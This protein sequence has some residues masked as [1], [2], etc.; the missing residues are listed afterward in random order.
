MGKT[1]RRRSLRK[2]I[3]ALL[4]DAETVGRQ[5][6]LGPLRRVL[7]DA[8]LWHVNRR[9]IA[10]GV[11]A[12]LFFGLLIPLAQIPLAAVSAVAL[13]A[14]VPAA[15]LATLVTNPF[16]FAPIY[17]LAYKLGA[18]LLGAPVT[19]AEEQAAAAA[20]E[21]LP[22]LWSGL[23]ALGKPLALGLVILAVTMSALAYAAV[24]LLW[25]GAASLAVRR[26]RR[27]RAAAI[28]TGR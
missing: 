24:H 18:L 5:R 9:G 2:R 28:R 17:L 13:R 23:A 8:R 26:R 1:L 4:P 19:G 25:R 20:A 10:L 12:G 11:A 16:T 3:R 27:R 21:A 14:N 22:S 6:L 15:V 7:G